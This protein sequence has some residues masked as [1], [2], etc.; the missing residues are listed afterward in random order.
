[1]PNSCSPPY[2]YR[3][4]FTASEVGCIAP[5]YNEHRSRALI[6][7]AFFRSKNQSTSE[8]NISLEMRDDVLPGKKTLFIRRYQQDHTTMIDEEVFHVDAGDVPIP[9]AP[10]ECSPDDITSMANVVNAGSL[11]VEMTALGVDVYDTRTEV[12]ECL[13]LFNELFMTG[14]DGGPTDDSELA[15]IRTGPERTLIIIRT[16]EDYQGNDIDPPL[17]RKI[18]QWDGYSWIPY[19][20]RRPG[21]CPG[22]DVS[23]CS[24]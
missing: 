14:G 16:T 1:M 9:P 10:Q 11:L 6:G 19:C 22:N 20:N 21:E 5:S 8:N 23:V 7:H 12:S 4:N 2:T 13:P 17:V 3:P 18:Q 24:T 15:N